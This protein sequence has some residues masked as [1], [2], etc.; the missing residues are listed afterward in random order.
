MM[1][2]QDRERNMHEKL[3]KKV[4]SLLCWMIKERLKFH[5]NLQTKKHIVT[6]FLGLWH[7]VIG[8]TSLYHIY[9]GDAAAFCMH[10]EWQQLH[11]LAA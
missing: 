10:N 7:A 3:A 1:N 9:I 11:T 8:A 2:K 5:F 6:T 4:Q